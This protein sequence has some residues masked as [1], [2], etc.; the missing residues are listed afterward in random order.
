MEKI[1]PSHVI[2]SLAL[3]AGGCAAGYFFITLIDIFPSLWLLL[4]I[5]LFLTVVVL[6]IYAGVGYLKEMIKHSGNKQNEEQ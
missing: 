4:S 3:I 5:P 2:L 6:P 1:K